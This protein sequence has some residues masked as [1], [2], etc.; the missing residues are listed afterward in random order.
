MKGCEELKNWVDPVVNHFW[1]CCQVAEGSVEELKV[2]IILPLQ[3]KVVLAHT[4][5]CFCKHF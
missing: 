4:T 1:Y 3:I 5:K 2:F